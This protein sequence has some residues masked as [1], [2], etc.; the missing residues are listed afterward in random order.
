MAEPRY[1]GLTAMGKKLFGWERAVDGRRA[2]WMKLPLDWF[3]DPVVVTL[4][5]TQQMVL[6]GL[7]M[8]CVKRD[9]S[10]PFSPRSIR[11]SLNLSRNPDLAFFMDQ[12][13]IELDSTSSASDP[14][15]GEER[16]EIE[17]R[18]RNPAT[19]V[20]TS[21]EPTVES[22]PFDPPD[23]TSTTPG[24][25][26]AVESVAIAKAHV[27]AEPLPWNREA[28]ELW[29]QEYQG[30]P[31]K[32]F[33]GALKPLVRKYTWE[34]VRPALVAYM[35][36]TPCEYVNVAGKFGAAFGTW[37]GRANGDGRKRAPPKETVADR[38][39]RVLGLP[40][41]GGRDD[42]GADVALGTSQPERR[43]QPGGESG[44][45][46]LVQQSASGANGGRL[47]RGRA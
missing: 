21:P 41:I 34:R 39:R 10:V 43:L 26:P 40:P 1:F 30:D 17:E 45:G 37:E 47:S 24:E 27:L 25:V 32:Q 44:R 22:P 5:G 11:L 14:M 4:N 18:E 31:P 15:R 16:E 38:S 8:L 46:D 42:F 9:N 29:F 35:A 19:V 23:D 33:F 6:L 3:S 20:A 7:A 13:F 28:A 2:H 36:E 12:G